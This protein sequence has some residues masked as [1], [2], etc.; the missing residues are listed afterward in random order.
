M[1]GGKRKGAGGPKGPRPRSA[2]KVIQIRVSPH[3]KQVLQ[4]RA[5]R[6]G[7]SV[8]EFIKGRTLAGRDDE[9]SL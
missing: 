9:D 5:A 3:E 1:Q 2:T 8:T 4:D 6:R 7:M